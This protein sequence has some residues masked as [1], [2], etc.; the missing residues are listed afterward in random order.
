MNHPLESTLDLIREG[1][2]ALPA[3]SSSLGQRILRRVSTV[4]TSVL[5]DPDDPFTESLKTIEL[6]HAVPDDQ[7]R[8][9]SPDELFYWLF[10]PMPGAGNERRRKLWPIS[11]LLLV[12]GLSPTG[13]ES[14]V[15]VLSRIPTVPQDVS[16]TELHSIIKQFAPQVF[17]TLS[18]SWVP[19]LSE[20]VEYLIR[21]SNTSARLTVVDNTANYRGRRVK[22]TSLQSTYLR[23]LTGH[24][25]QPVTH[26]LLRELGVR[27]PRDLKHDLCRK[28][29]KHGIEV[30]IHT[31]RGSKADTL[32]SV[33][34]IAVAEKQRRPRAKK[35]QS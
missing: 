23:A 8:A 35:R 9:D 21:V 12:A 27:A 19:R 4:M 13:R 11:L 34:L 3:P 20:A 10:W 15:T 1:V 7:R 28:L 16:E 30:V 22:L 6:E 18:M 24:D 2:P 29:A 33:Q 26:A 17:D 14:L 5:E 31:L 25:G 32:V